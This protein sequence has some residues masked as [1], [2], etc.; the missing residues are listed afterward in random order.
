MSFSGKKSVRTERRIRNGNSLG[1]ILDI[2]NFILGAMVIIFTFVIFLNYKKYDNLFAV[3]FLLAALMNICMGIK[4]FKRHEMIKFAALLI[5]GI[6]LMS[7]TIISFMAF[8]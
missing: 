8:W 5:A 6:F 4:Y 1:N 2:I 7:M 3:V